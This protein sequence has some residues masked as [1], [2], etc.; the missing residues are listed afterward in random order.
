M[1]DR[2]AGEGG[3]RVD[4]VGDIGA[5]DGAHREQ[6]IKRQREIA[7]GDKQ[8]GERDRAAVGLLDGFDDFVDVDAAQHV[9]K[10]IAGNRDDRDADRNT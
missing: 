10:H 5:A 2:V 8:R 1:A 6:V 7:G 3:K 4:P 9:V